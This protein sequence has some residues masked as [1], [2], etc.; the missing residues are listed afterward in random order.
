MNVHFSCTSIYPQR[1]GAAAAA[2]GGGWYSIT[3]R[4]ELI[5]GSDPGTAQFSRNSVGISS[6]TGNF[7]LVEVKVQ[8]GRGPCPR[9][10]ARGHP[11]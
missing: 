3:P 1:A 9:G 10:V 6:D 2:A 4:P 5:P 8:S 7:F 11:T